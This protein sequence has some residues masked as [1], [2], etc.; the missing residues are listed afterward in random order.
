M[1]TGG[2]WGLTIVAAVVVGLVL[3]ALY[4]GLLA[5]TGDLSPWG[6][7]FRSNPTLMT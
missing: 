5:M 1:T 4:V 2:R 7:R 6:G 3:V